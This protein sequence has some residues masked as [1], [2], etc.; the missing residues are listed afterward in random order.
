MAFDLRE[1]GIGERQ[2]ASLGDSAYREM[3][4]RLV[5]G[6]YRPGHKMTVRGVA[7][8][9][10]VSSTPARDAINRLTGDGALIY[11]GPKTVIVPVLGEPDLREITLMRIALEG[12]AAELAAPHGTEQDLEI[13]G[14]LQIKINSALDRRDYEGA[15]WYNKEFHFHVY[16][17]ARL[18]HL[19]A[20]I[21]GLWLRIGPSLYN[22]YPSFAEER[23]GVRN[24]HMAMEAFAERDG[25]ALRAAFEN[26]IRV[27]YRH[28]RH[29]TRERGRL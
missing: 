4:E 27:G 20:T 12:L 14:E 3:K 23:C 17:L 24:H 10:G 19:V 7:E 9:L 5:R 2:A 21:E 18:P 22:L 25:A 29:A 26:D 15:L 8:E 28:L 1:R 11:A 6:V 16:R 13:L